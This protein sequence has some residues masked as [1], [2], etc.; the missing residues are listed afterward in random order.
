[1]GLN[2]TLGVNG[3]EVDPITGQPVLSEVDPVTGMIELSPPGIGTAAYTW[4]TL[5]AASAQVGAMALVTDINGG[6]FFRSNGTRWKPYNNVAALKLLGDRVTM[7]GATEVVLAQ[8]ALPAGILQN[9]DGLRIR[10]S[11]SKSSTSE[12][13]TLR[14]RLGT[15]GTT[16]DTTIWSNASIATVAI[17]AGYDLAFKRKAATEIIKTGSGSTMQPFAGVSTAV[18]PSP[19]TVANMD[20]SDLFLSLTCTM[21]AAVE[22]LALEDFICELLSK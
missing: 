20:S 2:A 19:V 11:L 17:S 15:F 6:T 4:A 12:T 5:P 14:L 3:W 22:T 8:V 21:S 7:T 13:A 1:M 16:G 10:Q 9:G 18:Y